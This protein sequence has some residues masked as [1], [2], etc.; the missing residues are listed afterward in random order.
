MPASFQDLHDSFYN[1]LCAGL[2]FVP[3]DNLQLI[4]P[5]APLVAGPQADDALWSYFNS[6]PPLS[7]SRDYVASGGNQFFSNYRG[8][9]SALQGQADAF[10][11]ELGVEGA[12][13][14]KAHLRALQ[15][16]VTATTT[17]I[18]EDLPHNAFFSSGQGQRYLRTP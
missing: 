17:P 14:W 8:L 13:A 3:Q 5:A 12:R 1:A 15:T 16:Y 4:Q 6:L 2:G 9:L 7:L 10:T 11:R 18:A